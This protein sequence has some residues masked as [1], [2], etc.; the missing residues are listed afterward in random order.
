MWSL[1]S[2]ITETALASGGEYSVFILMDVKEEH[3]NPSRHIWDDQEFYS[4]LM[5]RLVP[6]EFRAITVLFNRELLQL[7]YPKVGEYDPEHQMF[8]PLQLFAHHFPQ[9]DYFWTMEMVSILLPVQASQQLYLT[10]I[11][12][13]IH[14]TRRH[15]L[16]CSASI[17]AK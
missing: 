10:I 4:H 12:C 11:G 13:K 7:W 5:D 3:A 8:Q 6:A 16:S 2:L 9:F 17:R 15:N 14:W 1:R